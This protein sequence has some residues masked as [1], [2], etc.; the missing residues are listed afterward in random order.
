VDVSPRRERL[1]ESGAEVIVKVGRALLLFL[2]IVNIEERKRK[3]RWGNYCGQGY[4]WCG[5]TV[6]DKRSRILEVVVVR[7]IINL[8]SG[9]LEGGG[10]GKGL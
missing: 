5:G 1:G 2:G 7:R 10:N 8:G 3:E 4:R 6:P 9:N